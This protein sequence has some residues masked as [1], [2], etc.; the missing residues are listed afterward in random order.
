M[1]A[2]EKEQAEIQNE[3]RS[4]N[5]ALKEEKTALEQCASEFSGFGDKARAA[6]KTAM[7]LAAAAAAVASAMVL[8]SAT[9]GIEFESAFAGVRKTT[10]ATEEEFAELRAG[11]LEL[12]ESMPATAAEISA[13]AEAAGQLG[14][15]KEDLLDF[16]KVMIDLGESTN[17]SAEEAASQLAKLANITGMSADNYSRLGSTIVDLGNNFATTEADIVAMAMRLAA[18]GELAGLSEPQILALAAS[19]SSVGI[20]AEAGGSAMSKLLKMIQVAVETGS[21][22]LNDFA[23]IA[24]MTSE[25][26]VQAFEKD[27]VDALGAFIGGLNDTERNG[28]SAVA[29]LDEMEIKEVRLSNTILS[30]ANSSDVMQDAISTANE[31]WEEN[32]ALTKEAEQRYDTT[33]SKLS[34]PKEYGIKPWCCILRKF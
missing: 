5:T 4:T 9:A 27:A 13:V 22:E 8:L 6:A 10:D 11:I 17:L 14:I 1:N 25:E 20:E 30:L 26:F 19:M 18:T 34:N 3:I 29:I 33:E 15:K 21:E 24:G 31:A 28:K 12:A 2:A 32:T 16:T 23:G 7:E